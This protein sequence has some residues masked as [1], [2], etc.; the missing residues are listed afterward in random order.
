MVGYVPEGELSR[1]FREARVVVLPYSGDTG[2]SGVMHLAAQH[3]RALLMSDLPVLREESERLGL[4][5]RFYADEA[6]LGRALGDLGEEALLAEGRWNLE[7]MRA[8]HPVGAAL[9]WWTLLE[10][11]LARPGGVRSSVVPVGS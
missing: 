1:I 11:L 6:A 8:V 9:Q 4:A 7:A 5:V 2:T 10:A 3:G